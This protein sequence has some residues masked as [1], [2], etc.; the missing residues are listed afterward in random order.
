MNG[1]PWGPAIFEQSKAEYSSWRNQTVYRHFSFLPIYHNGKITYG[2]GIDKYSGD[3]GDVL[4][5]F[6]DYTGKPTNGKSAYVGYE[7]GNY[8]HVDKNG[9]INGF[10]LGYVDS[11]FKIPSI[12]L[13]VLLRN[14]P[15]N[16]KVQSMYNYFKTSQSQALEKEVEDFDIG[17]GY[18]YSGKC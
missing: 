10:H 4:W 7:R 8:C 5:G 17:N 13:S 14:K 9:E 11:Y 15:T 3:E 1:T 16:E 12:G 2:Y 18:K 6:I